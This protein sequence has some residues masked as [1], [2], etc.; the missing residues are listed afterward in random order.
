MAMDILKLIKNRRTI[1]K[2]KN[3]A[4]PK[5]IINKIIEAGRWAS[6]IH[7]FQ[8]W[9][10]IVITKKNIIKKLAEIICKESKN[11]GTGSNILMSSTAETISKASMLIAVYNTGTFVNFAK[12]F[13]KDYVEIASLSEIESISAAI[14][15]MII[16]AKNYGI[17][18]CWAAIPLFCEKDIS[19][20]INTSDKL[21]AI[22]T[23]GF[24]AEEGKRSRRKS[25]SETVRYI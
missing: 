18:S 17:G 2:Y 16:T 21:V 15:N 3:K 24:P 13:R 14:Q 19:R 11:I 9:M 5:K 20:L 1:R 8:P 7:G 22:L 25:V 6:S 10:F 12:K 4:V 23:L